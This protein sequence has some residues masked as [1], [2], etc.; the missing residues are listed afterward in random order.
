MSY[1]TL[2]EIDEENKE[3]REN[4]ENEGKIIETCTFKN[5]SMESVEA[6]RSSLNYDND[7]NNMNINNNNNNDNNM[8]INKRATIPDSTSCGSL[9]MI[10]IIISLLLLSIIII[11]I[12]IRCLR[13][14]K[15]EIESEEGRGILYS[16]KSTTM[17]SES[18]E[19]STTDT[20]PLLFS[21]YPRLGRVFEPLISASS[22]DYSSF[23]FGGGRQQQ[24]DNNNNNNNDNSISIEAEQFTKDH[25]PQEINPPIDHIIHIQ[26]LGGAK[27]WTWTP[28]DTLISQ[29]II[30]ITNERKDVTFNKR[31]NVMIQTNYPFFIPRAEGDIIY[32]APFEKPKTKDDRQGQMLHYFEITVLSNSNPNDTT[33]AIGLATKPYPSFR[34]PGWN[35]HS[36]GYHS[37]GKKFEDSTGGK[38]YG[39]KWGEPGDTIGCGYNPDAGYVFFTKNEQF[40]GNAYT[41]KS[42]IWFPTIGA[43]GPCTIQTNFGDDFEN[44]FRYKSAIGYGPG[45]PLLIRK[46]ESGSSTGR[47][48]RVSRSGSVKSIHGISNE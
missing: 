4:R 10:I 43:T 19:S 26:S 35:M 17:T 32:E 15:R 18:P 46:T 29:Q 12:C 13:R 1:L 37:I 24:D 3:N 28:D 27:A 9:C 38:D 44:D 2:M 41:G 42:H 40:L 5:S 45:G 21:N 14:K 33:I 25:P 23:W 11:T 30:S 31:S 6:E 48:S 47:R 16:E 39:P 7:N 36:V 8:N 34:L 22:S 20:A